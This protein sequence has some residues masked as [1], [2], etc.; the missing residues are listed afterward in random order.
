MCLQVGAGGYS[1]HIQ[2]TWF[3]ILL[4]WSAVLLYT[5][6]YTDNTALCVNLYISITYRVIM[7]GETDSLSL[8]PGRELLVL[9]T[10]TSAALLWADVAQK[11]TETKKQAVQLDTSDT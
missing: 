10:N 8:N 7:E 11:P 1:L 3:I 6:E 5:Y 2:K 9:A 4:F